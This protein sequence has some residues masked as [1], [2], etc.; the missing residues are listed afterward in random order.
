M[1]QKKKKSSYSLA[2][3]ILALAMTVLVASGILVYGVVFVM[4]LLAK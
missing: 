2:T 4:E 3:R 1:K